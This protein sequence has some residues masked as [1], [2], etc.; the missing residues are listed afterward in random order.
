MNKKIKKIKVHLNSGFSLMETLI[1]VGIVGIFL[2]LS[3]FAMFKQLDRA[4]IKA[5]K[6]EMHVYGTA[7]LEYL[8]TEGQL[9]TEEEG[10]MVLVQKEYIVSKDSNK[11]TDPWG[12]EYIYTLINDGKDFI[13]KSL[14]SD[15]QE[16][17]EAI[18]AKDIVFSSTKMGDGTGSS[19]GL[20]YGS[21]FDVE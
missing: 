16:G 5:A 7:L 14:G 2:G 18:T 9:P 20:D 4:K 10:L 21:D 17:G 11:L 1:W 6:Q 3:G 12:N 13:I 8:S 15:K 19:D